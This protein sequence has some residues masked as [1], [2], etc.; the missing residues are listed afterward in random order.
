MKAGG[1]KK[2]QGAYDE[3]YSP[4]NCLTMFIDHLPNLK[5]LQ[6]FS[7]LRKILGPLFANRRRHVFR[8]RGSE[9]PMFENSLRTIG[10]LPT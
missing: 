7:D 8:D 5:I 1:T 4:L 2:A 10:S 3:A 6:N 9:K